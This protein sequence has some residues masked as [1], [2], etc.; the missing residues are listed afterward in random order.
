VLQECYKSVTRVL[1]SRA[2][3]K[4]S[5]VKCDLCYRGVTG[6]IQGCYRGV[7]GVSQGCYKRVTRTLQASHTHLA[8]V[9][10]LIRTS[11][12][13]PYETPIEGTPQNA[14]S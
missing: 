5:E 10:P 8:R 9:L 3:T 7:T 4:V 13:P 6:V 11:R 12:N 14:Y 1:C 2:N